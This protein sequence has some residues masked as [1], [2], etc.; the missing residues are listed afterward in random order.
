[1]PK[2]AAL[3]MRDGLNILNRNSFVNID[4]I[5][6]RFLTFCD[7]KT[8]LKKLPLPELHF[9]NFSCRS[10]FLFCGTA[11]TVSVSVSGLRLTVDIILGKS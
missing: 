5:K 9:R 2:S 8:K 7:S 6:I 11:G 4:K 3:R 10:L 1:M